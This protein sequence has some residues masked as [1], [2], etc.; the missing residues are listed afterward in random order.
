M[1]RCLYGYL[2]F[3]GPYRLRLQD[4]SEDL[5]V[6]THLP[7]YTVSYPTKPQYVDY[8]LKAIEG[9]LWGKKTS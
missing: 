5:S 2:L 8:S 7:H 1:W 4:G 6:G 9:S 3:E